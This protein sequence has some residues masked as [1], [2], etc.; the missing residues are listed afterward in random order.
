MDAEIAAAAAAGV[1]FFQI[2]YYDDY[3]AE[4]APNARLLNRGLTQFMASPNAHRMHFYIEWCN[5]HPT[6]SLL[7]TS[8]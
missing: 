6:F 1:D 2:L 5:A 4:R 3:P 7:S 8:D